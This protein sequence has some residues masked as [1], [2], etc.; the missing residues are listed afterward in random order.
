MQSTVFRSAC[1]NLSEE[2]VKTT[3]SFASSRLR[4]RPDDIALEDLIASAFDISFTLHAR[5]L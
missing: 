4:V 5:S 3:R 1:R 2:V